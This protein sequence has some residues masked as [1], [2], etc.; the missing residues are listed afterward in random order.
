MS[1]GELVSELKKDR[2]PKK[3]EQVTLGG[4]VT[5]SGE[6]KL[7]VTDI[8][9]VTARLKVVRLEAAA[10]DKEE[11]QL[12]SLLLAHPEAK[13]GFRNSSIEIE[14]TQSIDLLNGALL[15]ALLETKTFTQACNLSLSQPKV[16]EI[17]AKN[18]KVANA[19]KILH[20]RKIKTVK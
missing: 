15:T 19:I 17:A 13:A 8:D 9:V 6:I 18:I 5:P 10:L 1:L 11:K 16:R 14:G 2:Q 7:D 20:G 4:Q 12:K 3:T